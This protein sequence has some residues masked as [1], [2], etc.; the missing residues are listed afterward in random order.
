MAGTRGLRVLFAPDKFKGSLTAEA[1]ARAMVRGWCQ[2]RRQDVAMAMPM[3]DGGDGFGAIMATLMGARPRWVRTVDA[4]H[5]PIR[6]HW[7]WDSRR[8][9]AVVES[10]RTI[11]LALLPPGRFHPFDLDT[12]GLAQ[13]LEAVVRAGAHT[14]LIGIGG[15]ATNDGGFGLA[16]ALGWAFLDADGH[17][18]TRWTELDRLARIEPPPARP[19]GRLRIQVAVDVQN[20]LLGPRGASRVY[21]PQKGLRPEDMRKA[22]RALGRLARVARKQFGTDFARWPGSGAAGGLGFG[23]FAFL[24]ARPVRGFEVFARYARLDAKLRQ[25][26]LVV[27]GEGAIDASTLMGKGV[28]ELA[29]RCRAR[30][31]PCL[32]LGGRVS[33]RERLARRFSAALALTDLTA[34]AEAKREPARWLTRLAGLAAR[35]CE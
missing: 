2:A 7:S 10:A 12:A 23:L 29:R 8:R 18:I 14:C 27:T 35:K 30:G 4:A 3:S 31:V 33:D 32:A 21:G 26:D 5:R 34:E 28:G 24:G 15:S 22:E 20:R 17:V 6:T 16:C 9:L 11:G 25:V 1:A 19:R 13:V